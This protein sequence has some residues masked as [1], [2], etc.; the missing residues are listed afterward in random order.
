MKLVI[1]N[2]SRGWGGLQY[3]ILLT[4]R[5]LVGLGH[6][7]IVVCRPH[8][9]LERALRQEG[10]ATR[11]LRV[12]GDLG[13]ARVLRFTRWLRG[14]RPDAVLVTTWKKL[15]WEGWAARRAGIRRVAIPLGN[16]RPV[17]PQ[18]RIRWALRRYVDVIIANAEVLR[19][20][21]LREAPWFPADAVRVVLNG[22]E[23]P[24]GEPYDLRAEL[25]LE[26]A[27]RLLLGIGRLVPQKGFDVLLASF[28]EV[29]DPKVHVAIAGDGPDREPLEARARTLGLTERVH[30]LG[31]RRDAARLLTGCDA[32]V[33][34]SRWEGMAFS[35]LEAM[36]AGRPIVATDVSG[37]RE[38]LDVEEGHGPA[39]W[40]VPPEAPAALGQALRAVLGDPAE[41]HRRAEEAARRARE[42][43]AVERMVL[44][45]ERVLFPSGVDRSGAA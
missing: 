32:Y 2:H 27:A 45:T 17:P 21:W 7:V 24:P 34:S 1:T 11:R 3:Q 9:A 20:H 38:A 12:S 41:A 35:M 25:G 43:F 42:R 40:I 26:D 23:P 15:F 36:A 37:V 13:L 14:E 18:R 22:V 30:W 10:I 16:Q 29:E 31:F 6:Q 44:E 28:R 39:G 19:Q 4:A 33:L 5:G 8:S